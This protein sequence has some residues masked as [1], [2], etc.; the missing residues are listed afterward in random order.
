[1]DIHLALDILWQVGVGAGALWVAFTYSRSAQHQ[2]MDEES[3]TLIRLRGERIGDLETKVNAMS[4]KLSELRGEIKAL[5]SIKADEIA[6]K[7]VERL[8]EQ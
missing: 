6:D 8:K 1:M 7:V 2:T 3:T 5:E 4:T